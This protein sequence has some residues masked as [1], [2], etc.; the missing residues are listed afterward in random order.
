MLSPHQT[1]SCGTVLFRWEHGNARESACIC[2]KFSWLWKQCTTPLKYFNQSEAWT[3]SQT[4]VG[5]VA[6]VGKRKSDSSGYLSEV[7]FEANLHCNRDLMVY[8]P[9]PCMSELLTGSHVGYDFLLLVSG[10][11][12]SLRTSWWSLWLWLWL[13]MILMITHWLKRCLIASRIENTNP[14]LCASHGTGNKLVP[15]SLCRM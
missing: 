12:L 1:L 6:S 2:P 5:C 10:L 8:M 4:K 14:S 7:P 9:W 3:F 13:L 11:I 15:I